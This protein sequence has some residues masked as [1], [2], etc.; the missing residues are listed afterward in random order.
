MVLSITTKKKGTELNF[1]ASPSPP[2]RGSTRIGRGTFALGSADD[3]FL[4]LTGVS[5]EDPEVDRKVEVC[6][7]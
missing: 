4:E 5:W 6:C 3:S 1:S 2:G 7:C